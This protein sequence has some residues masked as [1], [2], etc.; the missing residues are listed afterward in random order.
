MAHPPAYISYHCR[1]L[2]AVP[3]YSSVRRR[4]VS[5]QSNKQSITIL[6]GVV[7]TP[8]VPHLSTNS[9]SMVLPIFCNRIDHRGWKR[10]KERRT[11]I[12]RE[13]SRISDAQSAEELTKLLGCLLSNPTRCREMALR[14]LRRI[15]SSLALL[16]FEL[17]IEEGTEDRQISS[18]PGW[19]SK[20]HERLSVHS[21]ARVKYS[22]PSK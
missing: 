18:K 15:S 20:A 19:R 10:G 21:P 11:V 7:N 14:E 3:E 1:Q 6:L 17:R 13:H 2:V 9:E 4:Y 12:A 22:R 5:S 16:H 8:H